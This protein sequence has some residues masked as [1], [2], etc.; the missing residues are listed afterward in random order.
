MPTITPNVVTVAGQGVYTYNPATGDLTFDPDNGFTS[1]PTP[2]P[3]VLMETLT[4]LTDPA[5]VTIDYYQ[6]P[7]IANDDSSLGNTVGSNATVNL[8]VNDQ[9]ADGSQATTTNTSVELIDPATGMPTVT[10]NVVTISGQGVYTY[11]PSTGDLTFDPFDGFTT[12]PTP[13]SYILTET[14]T[15]LTDD[16]VVTMTYIEEP[17]V[18]NDDNSLGNTVGTN[19]TVNLLY[20]RPIVGWKSG[21]YHQYFNCID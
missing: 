5:I 20:Q 19:A 15:G 6:V 7:P 2:I 11:N 21:Y 8:L 13:I 14:L 12:D 18:A 1:D 16:A 10:P 17:P 9:L 3:Y 4:G